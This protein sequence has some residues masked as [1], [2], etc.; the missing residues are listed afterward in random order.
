MKVLQYLQITD[1]TMVTSIKMNKTEM[2]Q[3]SNLSK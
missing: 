3:D 2:N 1:I